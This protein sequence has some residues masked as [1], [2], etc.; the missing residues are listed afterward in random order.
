MNAILPNTPALNSL[1][2]TKMLCSPEAPGSCNPRVD[3]KAWLA[4][5]LWRAPSLAEQSQPLGSRGWPGQRRRRLQQAGR[6]AP[7][8]QARARPHHRLNVTH[9]LVINTCKTRH[10]SKHTCSSEGI[11]H[12]GASVHLMTHVRAHRQG[13]CS[14]PNMQASGQHKRTSDIVCHT[15]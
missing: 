1:S 10:F 15:A 8:P 14:G 7:L 3:H 5:S 6:A 11:W 12:I 4:L 13:A 9:H 2:L